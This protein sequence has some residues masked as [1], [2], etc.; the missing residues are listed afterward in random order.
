MMLRSLLVLSLSVFLVACGFHLRGAQP[1]P[2]VMQRT[3]IAGADNSALY[4]ELESALLAAGA[5]VVESS[6]A[7]TATLT[8]HQERYSRRVLSVDNQGR[9]SEYELRLRIVFSLIDSA[10]NVIADNVKFN[11]L[12]DYSFDPDN[13][14]ASGGQEKMLKTEMRRYAARQILRRLQSLAQHVE[15]EGGGEPAATTTETVPATPSTVP[16]Q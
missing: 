16:A 1:I 8:I 12:R 9:A 7:A 6:E 4:Y 2:A 15:V 11:V 14:L 10:G 3:W 5:A 13:V